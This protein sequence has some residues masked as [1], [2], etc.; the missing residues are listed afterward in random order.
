MSDPSDENLQQAVEQ[1]WETI[2]PVWNSVRAQVRL[3]AMEKFDISVEQ[4]HIL[5][6]IRRGTCSASELAEMGHI[7]RPAISQAVELLVNK[8]LVNRHTS[9]GDRR[10]IELG[11]TPQGAALLEDIFD[12]ASHWMKARLSTLEKEDLEAVKMGLL[13]LQEAFCGGG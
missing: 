12:Q 5:R 4:F 13:H 2:P 9:T 7:S 8:G 1:F 11:L 3:T 10:F 6:H